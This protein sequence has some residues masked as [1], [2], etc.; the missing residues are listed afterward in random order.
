MGIV[1]DIYVKLRMSQE[2]RGVMFFFQYKVGK[3]FFLN[4]GLQRWLYRYI[5]VLVEL[6][7]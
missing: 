1:G 5:W 6:L 3:L 4:S 7:I 2:L